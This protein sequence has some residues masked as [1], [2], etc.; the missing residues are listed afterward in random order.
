M[1]GQSIPAKQ[2]ESRGG[3]MTTWLLGQHPPTLPHPPPGE[4]PHQLPVQ[5][6]LGGRGQSLR[7][8]EAGAVDTEWTRLP[9]VSEAQED[10]REAI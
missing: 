10:W 6:G 2:K 5:G 8:T 9:Q 3:N 7:G 4:E 1:S